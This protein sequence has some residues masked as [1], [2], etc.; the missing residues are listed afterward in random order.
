MYIVTGAQVHGLCKTRYTFL[1]T[2]KTFVC[3]LRKRHSFLFFLFARLFLWRTLIPASLPLNP[4]FSFIDF[5]PT[6]LSIPLIPLLN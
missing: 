5:N 3:S 4:T 2:V 6:P 1:F